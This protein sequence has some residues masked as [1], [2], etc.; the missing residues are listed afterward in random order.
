MFRKLCI[1]LVAGILA[2]VLFYTA[3]GQCLTA[4][5][6]P[7]ACTGTESLATDGSTINTATTQWFY[8]GSATAYDNLTM[9]GGT[10]IVCGDLIVDKF[11]FHSGTIYILP[12][13]RFAIGSGTGSDME[14]NCAVYN[15]GTFELYRSIGMKNVH[16]S[17]LQPNVI[18]NAT[19]SSVFNINNNY[20]VLD[21]PYSWFVNN[22]NANFHGLVL[23]PGC[24]AGAICMNSNSQFHIDHLVNKT[25]NTFNVPNGGAC[26]SVTQL[27]QFCQQLTNNPSVYVCIN[28]GHTTD[29]S[30]LVAGGKHN[31]WG[32]AQVFNACPGC[33]TVTILP[34]RFTAFKVNTYK[35]SIRLEWKANNYPLHSLFRA[36]RSADG[37]HFSVIETTVVNETSS[38]SFMCYDEHPPAGNNYYRI[39]CIDPVSGLRNA[40]MIVMG[41]NIP[42][43]S[44]PV[45]PNP[46]ATH[47]YVTLTAGEQP[48]AVKLTNANGETVATQ[49]VHE[50]ESNRIGVY[51]MQKTT[52]GLYI[53]HV[54][55]SSGVYV[56]KLMH[57]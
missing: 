51:T 53:L 6:A 35:Q 10:L 37:I 29:S 32:N 36:E 49:F 31:A 8:A 13:A 33:A 5:A 4:P 2:Q 30:C 17:A 48:T 23:D 52:P 22:G 26:F 56:Q 46:F 9:N 43:N 54:T 24:A 47:F 55:T 34:V 20:L 7:A 19:S 15:Y 57:H 1:T 28:P 38:G 27:S 25:F 45:Y 40:S 44:L 14:G 42:Q 50:K 11:F 41:K 39:V 3:R 21:N 12:G 16:A 18:I